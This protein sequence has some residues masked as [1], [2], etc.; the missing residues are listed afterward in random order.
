[1]TKGT[2]NDSEVVKEEKDE[3]IKFWRSCQ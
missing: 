3:V 2:S 1:V